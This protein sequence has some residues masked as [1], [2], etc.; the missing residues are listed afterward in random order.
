MFCAASAAEGAGD[1]DKKDAWVH[2][3]RGGS[4][5]RAPSHEAQ[6]SGRLFF[7]S[8]VSFA[9]LFLLLGKRFRPRRASE[10]GREGYA[11]DGA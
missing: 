10:P 6:V 4:Q 11:N 3:R 8:R 1:E 7:N 9:R 5:T 2:G